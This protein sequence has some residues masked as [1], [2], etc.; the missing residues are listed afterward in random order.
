MSKAAELANLIGN[1]NMGGGG[2]NRNVIINGAMNVKQ[3][4]AGGFT[5]V[6]GSS[7]YHLDRW[8]F[9]ALNTAGR[10]SSDQVADAPTGFA[11]SL[12]LTCTTAD[13]SI[14]S[15]EQLLFQQRIEGQN[16]QQFCK[17][18]SDAKPF[19][20]SLY[21][22]G[23]ASATYVCELHDQDNGRQISKAFSVTT[24]WTRIEITFPADTTGAFDDDNARSLNLNIALHGGSDVTSGTL[25]ETWTSTTQANRYVGISSFFDSTDRTFF[26]TGVQLE[27]GQNPTSFEH[28]PYEKEL[29][30]CQRYYVRKLTGVG[31]GALGV[32]GHI[33][34]GT[35]A[36]VLAPLPV[37]MRSQGTLSSGG[38]I[39]CTAPNA[40]TV[41]V[42]LAY[43]STHLPQLT[44]TDSGGFTDSGGNGVAMMG[45]NDDDAY[46]AFDA[47]L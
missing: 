10:F 14:A 29:L 23:N 21:V 17:G 1:I 38:S 32:G 27:V 3:R 7:V 18:T 41:S 15:D 8:I 22:K 36:N 4:D 43:G 11:N 34:G 9:Y 5:G 25:S 2:V 46:I 45:N 42:A 44:A 37:E 35:T 33:I 30:S 6:G 12:R 39:R 16:V 40:D 47:E 26:I 13:T 19:A 24:D 20:V 31:Y 28:I